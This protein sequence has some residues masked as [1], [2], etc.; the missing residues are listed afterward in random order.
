[1]GTADLSVYFGFGLVLGLFTFMFFL[2]WLLLHKGV[3]IKV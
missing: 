1:L 3:G 2:A